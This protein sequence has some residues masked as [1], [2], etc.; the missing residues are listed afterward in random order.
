MGRI[1]S[2]LMEFALQVLLG[3]LHIRQGHADVF[4]SEQL[5]ERWEADP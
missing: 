1:L 4:M 2:R 3:N 5:H